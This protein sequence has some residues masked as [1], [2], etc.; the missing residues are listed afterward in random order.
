[1]SRL[2]MIDVQVDLDLA[3]VQECD[4]DDAA[5]DR[6][7]GVVARDIVAADHVE[8]DVGALAARRGE[9]RDDEILVADS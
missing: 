9:R 3:P 7:G 8:D 1:M 6:R 4:L 5:V 2:A